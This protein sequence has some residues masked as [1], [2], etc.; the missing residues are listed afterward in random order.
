MLCLYV[1]NILILGINID[2]FLDIRNFLSKYFDMK[3][4]GEVHVVFS[5]KLMR[6]H[7]GISIK[8]ISLYQK[9]S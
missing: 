4:M 6:F 5:I 7:D 3:D 1:D 2:I 8:S 9:D